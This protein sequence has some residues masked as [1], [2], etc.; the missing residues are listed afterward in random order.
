MHHQAPPLKISYFI[1]LA[2]I[3]SFFIC[4]GA[5]RRK[6]T[7]LTIQTSLPFRDAIA[8]HSKVVE[9]EWP[10][11]DVTFVVLQVHADKVKGKRKEKESRSAIV[12]EK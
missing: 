8:K 10:A 5:A 9:A 7:F 6:H 3:I 4:R 12:L 2:G 1:V 11:I